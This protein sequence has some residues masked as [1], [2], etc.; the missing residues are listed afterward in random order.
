MNV[1]GLGLAIGWAEEGR[2]TRSGGSV[3]VLGGGGGGGVFLGGGEKGVF[4]VKYQC[5]RHMQLTIQQSIK[6]I[7]NMV[8][9]NGS[10]L[11][12]NLRFIVLEVKPQT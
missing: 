10:N 5:I 2:V 1:F 12:I 4:K 7:I 6:V 9:R 3:C 11:Y 8:L